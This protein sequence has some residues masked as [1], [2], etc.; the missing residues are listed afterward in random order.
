[1]RILVVEDEPVD[2]ELIVWSLRAGGYTVDLVTTGK[3]GLVAARAQQY[4]VLVLDLMLP[5]M[6]GIDIVRELRAEKRTTPILLLTATTA[7]EKRVEA[8]DAGAD[9]Y[10]TKPFDIGELRARLRALM[11]RA[12]TPGA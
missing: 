11:R 6:T 12:G 4:D 2:L 5:D 8:L 1:M 9:D 7:V 10:L 3:D